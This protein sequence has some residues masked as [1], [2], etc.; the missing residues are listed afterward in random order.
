MWGHS[1]VSKL[2]A[3]ISQGPVWVVNIKLGSGDLGSNA[4]F[5]GNVT[6]VGNITGIFGLSV[7]PFITK[8]V[9]Q[10]D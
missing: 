1:A 3:D 5:Q 4:G 10:S 2:P 7:T 6:L 8:P 9:I